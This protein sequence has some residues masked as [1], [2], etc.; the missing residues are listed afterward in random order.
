MQGM[1]ELVTELAA[2]YSLGILSDTDPLHWQYCRQQYSFLR[3]FAEP[4]LSFQ[5]GF[6]KPDPRCYRLAAEN[7]GT[8]VEFCLFIDDRAENVIGARQA[9]MR[10][11]QFTGLESLRRE[12]NNLHII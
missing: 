12:L 1:A 4:T 3:L 2:R 9:G 11:L 8:S 10:A 7:T 5:T 6:L